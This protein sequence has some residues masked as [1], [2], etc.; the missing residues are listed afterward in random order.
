MTNDIVVITANEIISL[1]EITSQVQDDGAGAIS[2]FS[3]TTRN[4]FQGNIV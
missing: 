1:D 2:T 3:G 4:T